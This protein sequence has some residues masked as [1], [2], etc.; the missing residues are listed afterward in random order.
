MLSHQNRLGKRLLRLHALMRILIVGSALPQS[1]PPGEIDQALERTKIL[2]TEVSQRLIE[3]A[4]VL[5]WL[6]RQAR[7]EHLDGAQLWAVY[8]RRRRLQNVLIGVGRTNDP[9]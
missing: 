5:R 4:R 7:A 1:P 6:D 2:T 9:W 8:R 3:L